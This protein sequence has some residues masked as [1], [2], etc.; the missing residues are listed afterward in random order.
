VYLKNRGAATNT[1][2]SRLHGSNNPFNGADTGTYSTIACQDL[3]SD[4]DLD[5]VLEGSSGAFL[6]F[7]NTGTATAPV[8]TGSKLG[9]I[10]RLTAWLL[11][12]TL[13][14]FSRISTG[15]W[16]TDCDAC[17]A[18]MDA[19]DTTTPTKYY[20]KNTGTQAAPANFHFTARW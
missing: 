14:S 11:G 3:D 15:T 4:G 20:Y 1:N 17:V 8:F 2:F 16:T 5:C 10:T 19:T 9:E 7:K 13:P 6:C 18:G 12:P